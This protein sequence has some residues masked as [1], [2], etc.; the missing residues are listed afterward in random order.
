MTEQNVQS[1]RVHP[2][3]DVDHS[4]SNMRPLVLSDL[5]GVVGTAKCHGPHS[6]D[7]AYFC[8]C[9]LPAVLAVLGVQ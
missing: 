1:R 7:T 5:D 4:A 2:A 3:A 9:G 8:G 6:P